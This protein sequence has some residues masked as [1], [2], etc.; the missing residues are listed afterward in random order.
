MIVPKLSNDTPIK[1]GIY[2]ITSGSSGSYLNSLE[3]PVY[4]GWCD[5]A[6]TMNDKP[7]RRGK[8][9]LSRLKRES[10]ISEYA[11]V[12]NSSC[13]PRLYDSASREWLVLRSSRG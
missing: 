3:G 2:E 12:G 8:V 4:N 10:I 11:I 7:S 1:P 6:L 13:G 5:D 9:C